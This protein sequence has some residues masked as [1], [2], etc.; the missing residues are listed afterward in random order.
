MPNTVRT[1]LAV[2]AAAFIAGGCGSFGDE[3]GEDVACRVGDVEVS[4]AS[5]EQS[6]DDA[7]DRAETRGSSRPDRKSPE[8]TALESQV[9][10][11]LLRDAA[12]RHLAEKA[13]VEVSGSDVDKAVKDL[14]ETSFG[15]DAD[16]FERQLEVE[17]RSLRQ[18]RRDLRSQLYLEGL[19]AKQVDTVDVDRDDLERYLKRHPEEFGGRGEQRRIQH[20]LIR[21]DGKGGATSDAEAR[22]IAERVATQL[23]RNGSEAAMTRVSRALSDD[24]SYGPTGGVLEIQRG[25]IGEAFEQAAFELD[26]GEIS[27]PFQTDLGWHVLVPRGPVAK[28]DLPDLDDV[29][30]QVRDAAIA[31]ARERSG[32]GLQERLA[33]L[34]ATA[35]CQDGIEVD[36]DPTSSP[37]PDAAADPAAAS[38]SGESGTRESEPSGGND[39]EGDVKS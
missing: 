27:E 11:Q 8:G 39:D 35:N 16:R 4:K 22:S 2:L 23:G 38:D 3:L 19:R 12:R 14:V 26:E 15:G 25:Q 13:G 20:V 32:E 24:P 28:P 9:L 17:G 34:E 21:V 31:A 10:R 33:E 1:S 18:V 36:T 29:R 5:L 30:D 37:T 7:F 6:I